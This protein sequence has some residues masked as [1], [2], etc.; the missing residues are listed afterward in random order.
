MQNHGNPRSRTK[1]G[2]KIVKKI[3]DGT[4][5]ILISA[6]QSF[7]PRYSIQIGRIRDDGSVAPFIPLNIEGTFNLTFRVSPAK[8]FTKLLESAEELILTDASVRLNDRVD[9]EMA[10]AKGPD[11]TRKTGKTARKKMKSA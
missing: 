3:D 1:P 4:H 2:W 8:T 9:R 6:L 10:A 5:A 11:T 7:T